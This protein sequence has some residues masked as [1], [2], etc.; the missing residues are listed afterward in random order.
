MALWSGENRY[1]RSLDRQ[2][3]LSYACRCALNMQMRS[4]M[5]QFFVYVHSSI[6][7]TILLRLRLSHRSLFV[8]H[9]P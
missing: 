5:L 9:L 3:R 4:A 8:Y 7:V 2:I 1:H 6:L